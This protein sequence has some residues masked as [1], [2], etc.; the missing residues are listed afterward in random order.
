MTG[1]ERLAELEQG[2][3]PQMVARMKS[4]FAVMADS[5]YLPGY[6]LLLAYPEVDHLTDLEPAA[7][8]QFL[9]DMSVLGE[10][11]MSAT[12]SR[13]VNYAILGNLDPFLHAHVWPRYDWENPQYKLSPPTDY[14]LNVREAPSNRY[15]ATKHDKILQTIR[16]QVL[17]RIGADLEP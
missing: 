11:V 14:P 15:E 7:R 9:L 6:C 10:A 12:N 1:S 2:R 3:N 17:K 16:T 5:Q 13:R 8:S 4:G